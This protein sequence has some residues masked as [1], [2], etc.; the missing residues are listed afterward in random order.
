MY[1]RQTGE[2]K[3]K[4]KTATFP[5]KYNRLSYRV[6]SR[7]LE[8]QGTKKIIRLIRSSTSER[9]D[10]TSLTFPDVS[11]ITFVYHNTRTL[12]LVGF[13]LLLEL[14]LFVCNKVFFSLFVAE[15]IYECIKMLTL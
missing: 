14:W 3:F 6:D 4:G 1:D 2:I 9:Y 15:L 12:Y 10:K 5:E 11:S 8:V 13:L 7:Y